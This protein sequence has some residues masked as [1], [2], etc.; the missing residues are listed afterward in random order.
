M[1]AGAAHEI[2]GS[3]LVIRPNRSLPVAGI[4]LLG[5]GF[6][7]WTLVLGAGFALAGASLILPF[8]ALEALVVGLLCFWIYRHLD[9]C[10]LIT[11]EGDR[12]RVMKR[13]G[14]AIARHEFPRHWARVRLDADPDGRAAGRLRLGA[15]G[16][17]VTLADDIGE[18]ER[19]AL[20]RELR[21]LLHAA[22][23]GAEAAPG[24]APAPRRGASA[25]P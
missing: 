17:Y 6:G 14:T 7:A 8:A 21:G 11:I 15:H 22:T 2:Q 4:V 24:A 23:T 12:V 16:T 18:H 5:V 9:D 25:G 13:R 3:S 20:A 10:E 19:A 1:S